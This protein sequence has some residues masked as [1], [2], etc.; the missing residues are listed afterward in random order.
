LQ[1][2]FDSYFG[3]PASLD[4]APYVYIKD[5]G[6]VAAPTE[7]I[8][9]SAMRRR[10]G[11]GFWRAGA[12]APGFTHEGVL[13]EITKQAIAFLE[14]RARAGDGKPF[15]LYFPLTAPHTPWM[16]T[17]EFRG[18]S[19]A[20]P[21]GDFTVQVDAT[22]GE[23]MK[24]LDRLKLADDTLLIVTSDNGAHW[25]P[26]DIEKYGHRANGPLRG[27]KADAWEGG[28][29][30]PFLARWPGKIKPGSVSRQTICHV[31]LLATCADLVGAEVPAGAGEDSASILPVLLG[32][33][34]ESRPV[35]E[36]VVHHSSR[37]VFAIR[38]GDWKLIEGLGSGGFSRPARIEPKAGGP[39][40]QLYHLGDDP[41]EKENLYLK[42][43]EVVER[44]H[45]L[46]EK[47]KEQG[48]SVAGRRKG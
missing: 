19:G 43:P 17:K 18:K 46:L 4:M 25:L 30:V 24:A 23:V 8:A 37:G 28:H 33:Q 48:Y 3:I 1:V 44:L 5:E 27:Q 39:K 31:D 29:R 12:I 34:P 14:G 38:Q 11:G 2:G 47:Y 7:K 36:A 9:A 45:R 20:G 32:K 41:A 10:G 35:H 26:S 22:V 6:V 13:P 15:F 42:K 16:P 40:G 21:Y